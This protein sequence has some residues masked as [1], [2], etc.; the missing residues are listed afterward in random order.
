MS[1]L[2]LYAVL[3]VLACMLI[4]FFFRLALIIAVV[5]AVMFA[6][7]GILGVNL[8]AELKKGLRK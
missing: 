6:L 2:L 7:Q 4:V 5:A 1:K 3:A 8:L